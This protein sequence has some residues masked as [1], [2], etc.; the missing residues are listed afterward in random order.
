MTSEMVIVV[1]PNHT[2]HRMQ[3]A[4][5]LYDWCLAEG[6]R[7]ALAT[8]SKA[9]VS[10]EFQARF[11]DVPHPAV[12]DL[13]VRQHVGTLRYQLWVLQCL[14]QVLKEHPEA[15]VLLPEGDKTLALLWTLGRASRRVGVLVMR[16][17]GPGGGL[18]SRLK[19]TVVSL[20]SQGG[21][22]RVLA[23]S[24]PPADNYVWRGFQAAP[25]PVELTHRADSGTPG[26]LEPV[27]GSSDGRVWIGLLGALNARKNV[28]RVLDAAAAIEDPQR[29][30]VLLAGRV[31]PAYS[32]E[33]AVSLDAARARG[34]TVHLED[35]F[36]TDAELDF[37][38]AAVDVAVTAYSH[39]APSGIFGK[40][41]SV[42]TYVVAAG[43]QSLREAIAPL[44]YRAIYSELSL[45]GLRAALTEAVT[46][47]QE[48]PREPI[49]LAGPAE[50]AA[51]LAATVC[52]N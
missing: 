17:P 38:I 3:Y 18:G 52:S 46:S 29:I 20:S 41:A 26:F 44:G 23:P 10:D 8:A 39:D 31:A 43:N 51:S 4:R 50:F 32:A 5:W 35:R 21:R 33:L 6:K 47:S 11:A 48:H 9:L 7:F 1:E 30:G 28:T 37:A 2:G 12:V 16:V 40:A 13:G 14:R 42:G 25:D 22:V 27:V 15:R 36:L 34:V 24:R 45:T 49:E 19:R